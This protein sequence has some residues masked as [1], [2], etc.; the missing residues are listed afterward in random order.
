MTER[1]HVPKSIGVIMDGNRRWAKE[2]NLPTFEGHRIGF[3]KIHDLVS[4]GQEAGIHEIILYAFSTENWDG[5]SEEVGYLMQILE[6]AFSNWIEELGKEDIRIRFI[7]ERNR[8]SEKIQEIIKEA[9]EKTANG[10]KGT[11]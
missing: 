9:E 7:G 6:H 1:S 8:A 4:W 11:L 2:N 3:D 10:T 5:S